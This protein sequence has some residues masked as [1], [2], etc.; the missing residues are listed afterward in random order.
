MKINFTKKEF[1]AL[2]EMLYIANWVISSHK[3]EISPVEKPYDDLEKKLYAL[4]ADF[5]CE[6]KITYSRELGEYCPTHYFE[7]ESP[8]M[9]FIDDYD[10]QTFWDEIVDRLATRDAIR[11]VGEEAYWKMEPIDRF[12]LLGE[13]IEKWG[14]EFEAHGLDNLTVK[15]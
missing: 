2:L 1:S 6:D 7:M 3:L 15:T 5:G 13:Y 14:T 10:A 9:E 11:E 4:A 8:H 12:S